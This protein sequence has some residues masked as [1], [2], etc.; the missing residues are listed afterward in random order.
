LGLREARQIPYQ[1]CRRFRFYVF[2]ALVITKKRIKMRLHAPTSRTSFRPRFALY[3]LWLAIITP[4]AALYLSDSYILSSNLLLVIVYCSSAVLCS[5]LSFWV[6]NIEGVVARYFAFGDALN[7]AKAVLIA[8]SL[9]F[10][11]LFS[12]TRLQGIPRSVPAIHA[13]ILGAG[14]LAARVFLKLVDA[15]RQASMPARPISKQNVILIGLND[16]SVLFIKFLQTVAPS[17]WQIIALLDG[18]PRL[19]NRSVHGIRV[20]GSPEHLATLI[21]EFGVHGLRTDRVILGIQQDALI[22]QQIRRTCEHHSADLTLLPDFFSDKSW[23]E[24]EP[25]SRDH[26]NTVAEVS[27]YF[28]YKARV[29]APIALGLLVILAPIFLIASAMTLIAVGSPIVFW[30][31]RIGRLGQEFLIYKLRTLSPAFDSRGQ[32]VPEKERL[33]RFGKR[34]RRMRLDELPQ[35]FNVIIGD[36]SLVGPRPLLPEDQPSNP[37]VRLSVRPGLTGWAQVNGGT[38]L[39]PEEKEQLDAWYVSHAS[40]WLDAKIIGLTLRFLLLGDRQ[41][42]N[43]STQPGYAGH[44]PRIAWRGPAADRGAVSQKDNRKPA[45]RGR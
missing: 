7:L 16:L 24:H 15:R 22:V 43:I 26:A 40:P 18:D 11:G 5:L 31:R 36:M 33:S 44:F 30:Q 10:V 28:R 1:I 4:Y 23:M 12:F 32:R 38:L 9:T 20:F 3:D 39:S 41:S 17:R 13:L 34:L 2:V 37:A 19:L 35:L 45:R 6:F 27:P 29:E 21:D 42:K 14:L 25:A 8:E